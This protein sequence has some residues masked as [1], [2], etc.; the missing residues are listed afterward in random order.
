[1]NNWKSKFMVRATL[2]IIF[3]YWV[4]IKVEN[5]SSQV[6]WEFERAKNYPPVVHLWNVSE[7]K[8]SDVAFTISDSSLDPIFQVGYK[9]S[10]FKRDVQIDGKLTLRGYE[11]I[12]Q[13]PTTPEPFMQINPR[14]YYK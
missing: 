4:N 9:L 2:V 1:M 14:E 8:N 11:I 10:I 5:Y 6:N 12:P 7:L 13:I 3:L